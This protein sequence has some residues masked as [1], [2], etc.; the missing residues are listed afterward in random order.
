MASMIKATKLT[1]EE[2]AE[3]KQLQQDFQVN[4]YQIGELN[5]IKR[6]I[7]NQLKEINTELDNQYSTIG[8]LS[9]KE[10]ELIDKLKSLYPDAS[11][12][13]ETG[14]LS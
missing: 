8:K 10:K 4:T 7:E 9:E 12:N 14:E 11:I 3:I 13:L 2:F 1:D 5:V 6:N